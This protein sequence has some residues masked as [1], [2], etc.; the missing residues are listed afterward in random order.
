MDEHLDR[1]A[2][3]RRRRRR[4]CPTR[5]TS[6]TF[7]HN[8][9]GGRYCIS[10][11]SPERWDP[12]AL[13]RR[14]PARARQDVL[15]DRRLGARLRVGPARGGSSRSRRASP[16]P[17]TT[18]QKWAVALA[19]AVLLDYGWPDRPLDRERTAVILGNAMAG[20][21][22][23]LTALR[24]ELP[25]VRAR[26]RGVI[27]VPRSC[28]PTCARR[29]S[30][31]PTSGWRSAFPTITED[32]M[33]GE[34]ANIIAGRV[35]NVFDLRGPNYV[36]DAACAS[37]MA[38]MTRQSKVSSHGEFDAAITGG[39]DRNMG[40]STFVKFCKIGALSA[41]GTRPYADGADGF[42][43]GEG[44][45]VF[46][47]KRLAD[48]ERD[49]DR[50]YAVIRGIGGSSDGRGK[51]ITAPN[52]VGQRLA[53]ERAW[54]S[55]GC[56]PATATYVEGHGTSTRV[57]DVVEVD[58]LS[59]VFGGAGAA[60]GSIAARV[61]EVEHRAP[62][63]RGGRG[64]V[65]QDRARAAPQGRPAQ[66][67]RQPSPTPTSTSRTFAAARQHRAARL[68]GARRSRPPPR[69]RERV[70]LRRHELP[71][72]ARGVRA[73]AV[74]RRAATHVALRDRAASSR[75]RAVDE[76]PR[77][78]RRHGEGAVARRP[79]DRRGVAK[80]SS[81]SGW[82]VAMR[83]AA[84]GH[85]PAR[86]RPQPPISRRRCASPSTT[87][88][89]PSSRDKVAK[90]RTALET[91]AAPMWRALRA[92]GVF[93]GRGAGGQGG[94]PLHRP[95]LAVRQHARRARA[96]ASRSS[97]ASFADADR[98]HDAAARPAAH[99]LHLRRR[100]PTR[101][102]WRSSKSS[103][104]RPRSPSRPCWPPTSRSPAC[105]PRTA[106]SPTW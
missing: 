65:A 15:E 104:S 86:R 58:A 74:V 49:G 106:S 68:G 67:Q 60:P 95:G 63:G 87:A 36:T 20:E 3:H 55:A 89:R 50:I 29:S 17:W 53:V 8:V 105:S 91:D 9:E 71:R 69:R 82:R 52:P 75:R 70:R 6:A 61:G 30:P 59:E 35:A 48:A 10:E 16:T 34:L 81:R 21:N 90:A 103:S 45:A 27:D 13:L 85:A 57:G 62:E 37:G 22:H 42:V 56:S 80:P 33:P 78:D 73:R 43:M 98:G 64:R 2:R 96:T 12:D 31:R 101:R 83:E 5:P 51:G 24:V 77:R 93:L 100:H 40:A 41:T 88:T 94:V 39:I 72:R 4:S 32:T 46:L 1:A 18:R 11:V 92:Q 38:A 23:Y 19:R 76:R 25:R 7:W 28:R 47:L 44:A 97:P 102:R 14:R 26:P 84:A 79:R 99:R 66:P 54:R